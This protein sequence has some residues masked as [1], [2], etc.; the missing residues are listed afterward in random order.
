MSQ[1]LSFIFLSFLGSTFSCG[2]IQS[3]LKHSSG[4]C[5]RAALP[6]INRKCLSLEQNR[7]NQ[8]ELYKETCQDFMVTI[9]W[10]YVTFLH[11]VQKQYIP[12]P[13]WAMK[14]ITCAGW[15]CQICRR[16]HGSSPKYQTSHSWCGTCGARW[17]QT[18]HIDGRSNKGNKWEKLDGIGVGVCLEHFCC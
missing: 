10:R 2:G 9:I 5:S 11:Q 18:S 3:C 8:S 7:S 15:I 4:K 17:E 12:K 14:I 6:D 1:I 16:C 13:K